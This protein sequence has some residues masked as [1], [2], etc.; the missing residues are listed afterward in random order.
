[1]AGQSVRDIRRRIQSFQ[2]MQQITKAME[3][4]AAA[5]LRRAEER[6]LA[7]RP[8]ADKLREVLA[9]LV[10]SGSAEEASE[11]LSLLLPRAEVRRVGLVP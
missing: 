1:M 8:F 4:V 6:A 9:R 3:L 10:A 7:A 11:G 2:N 5:K